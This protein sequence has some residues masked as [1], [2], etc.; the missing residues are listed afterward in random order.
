MLSPA[1]PHRRA[2][3]VVEAIVG[4]VVAHMDVNGGL[5]A[6]GQDGH[7]GQG[8]GGVLQAGQ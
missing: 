4:C 6:A 8:G 5:V 2:G 7:G 3:G 1:S